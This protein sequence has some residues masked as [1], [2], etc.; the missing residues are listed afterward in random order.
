LQVVAKDAD[1]PEVLF[2]S[3]LIMPMVVDFP[4]RSAPEARKNPRLLLADLFRAAPERRP[5]RF[6]ELFKL[7][8]NGH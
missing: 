8:C 1:P 2:T 7:Q 6:F 4:R 5:G 3:E